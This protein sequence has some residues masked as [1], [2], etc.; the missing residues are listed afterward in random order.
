MAVVL[1][2]N[3]YHPDSSIAIIYDG[4]L[5]FALSEE[6]VGERRKHSNA[7]PL[8][9][10]QAGLAFC[11]LRLEDIDLIGLGGDAKA[12]L[13]R[14]LRYSMAAY[15]NSVP[16]GLESFR[17]RRALGASTVCEQINSIN[18]FGEFGRL[19]SN[20]KIVAVEHHLCHI[21]SAFF[22]S[23]RTEKTVGFSYDGSGD[24]V[25]MMVAECV[26]TEII[27]RYKQYL[28]HSLG[29]F[30]TAMCQFL[31]FDRFGEEYKVMGLSPYGDD[32]YSKK[33]DDLVA[34]G[35][36]RNW[37]D[38]N[39]KFFSMHSG[40]TA[41]V[42][43]TN[44]EM[45][46]LYSDLLASHLGVERRK[47]SEPIEAEHKNLAKSIQSKFEQIALELVRRST[48]L[49]GSESIVLAGGCALN[50]VVNG[51][52]LSNGSTDDVWLGPASSDDGISTGAALWVQNKL[53]K[54]YNSR[55]NNPYLGPPVNS[56]DKSTLLKSKFFKFRFSDRESKYQMAAKMIACGQVIGWCTGRSE[57]GARALGNRSILGNPLNKKMKDMIN[58][59]IKKR[60]SFRPFA[61]AVLKED[62]S[63][64]FEQ[65]TNSPFMTFV[66]KVRPEWREALPAVTHVDGTA[67]VQTV[68]KNQSSEFWE[69]LQA[70]KIQTGVG[71]LLNTSFN[72][73]EPI[74]QTAEE[75]YQCFI[76]T[77]L[78]SL[79]IDDFLFSKIDVEP[80]I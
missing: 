72:E 68:E 73:N 65:S 64:F 41:G 71:M 63:I 77:D 28:P 56:P 51:K 23:G 9:A 15:Q 12:N 25:S 45:G 32:S 13:W 36:G 76:R 19:R 1:G 74:V 37:I 61:P 60:E 35:H 52:I 78:D 11:N 5:V 44:L 62:Q 24:F 49:I 34:V 6:R 58:L 39:S 40:G 3:C 42:E 50:G 48:T 43:N 79:F 20:V 17:K 38:L 80:F 54:S 33:L 55:L 75:A 14:K 26:N 8:H 69:L 70:V 59:K 21:S 22:T 2:I 53:V 27:P 66:V 18:Q 57:L 30:Y 29:I 16:A 10:L 7:F 46:C 67:R 4:E 47:R 31:G